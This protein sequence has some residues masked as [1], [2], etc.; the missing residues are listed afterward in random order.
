[1]ARTTSP[2]CGGPPTPT[3]GEPHIP[4]Q[5]PYRSEDPPGGRMRASGCS[6]AW[7][8]HLTGGQ[9]V[10]SS[11]LP[12][13]TEEDASTHLYRPASS[14][15]GLLTEPSGPRAVLLV[16]PLASDLLRCRGALGQGRSTDKL[17]FFL[18][19]CEALAARRR[20]QGGAPGAKR[21]RTTLRAAASSK[22]IRQA[23][24]EGSPHRRSRSQMSSGPVGGALGAQSYLGARA[25]GPATRWLMGAFPRHNCARS[26]LGGRREPRPWRQKV[27]GS[28]AA[29]HRLVGGPDA[30]PHRRT[31]GS[32]GATRG[33][34]WLGWR[35]GGVAEFLQDVAG[36]P[37][38]LAGHRQ[39]GP[40]VVDAVP[41]AAVVGMVRGA[42]GEREKPWEAPVP[43]PGAR[44]NAS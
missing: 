11:N 24:E 21:G 42:L 19:G 17:P 7:L 14:A 23:G 13:P 41:D 9:G 22:T 43:R 39:A 31:S 1:M 32:L 35:H 25:Q 28:R 3:S 36:P 4:A 10:G 29:G 18:H 38:D 16:D 34:R 44:L 8:A 33:R 37:A 26:L 5:L 27:G 6:A 12:S 30:H 40:V 20:G 2:R 15:N